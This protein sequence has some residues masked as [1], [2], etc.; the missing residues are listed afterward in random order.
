MFKFSKKGI[1]IGEQL[2]FS[3]DS[4]VKAI[5]VDDSHIEFDGQLASLS[6][7]AIVLLKRRGITRTSVQGTKYWLYNGVPVGDIGNRE[8]IPES[9][10]EAN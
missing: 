6:R 9:K 8:V 10:Q 2:T 3:L 1:L 7:M 5:V 4:N